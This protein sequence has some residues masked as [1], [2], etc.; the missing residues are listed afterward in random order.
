MAKLAIVDLTDEE[1]N[2]IKGAC[3][4]RGEYVKD[5]GKRLLLAYADGTIQQMANFIEGEL[6]GAQ[7][8]ATFVERVKQMAHGERQKGAGDG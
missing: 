5:V 3:A 4:T 2:R 1:K 8:Y 6:A 7:S